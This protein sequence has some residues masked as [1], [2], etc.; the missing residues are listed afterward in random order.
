MNSLYQQ[1]NPTVNNLSLSRNSNIQ[2][3][4]S[5]FKNSPNP[6][7]LL[8]N[9]IKNNP[10]MQNLY[11]LIQNSNKTPK[12]LFYTMANEKGVDPNSILNL[13]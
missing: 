3:I 12:E 6:Q 11:M 1:L 4:I 10:Q 2:N 9:L 8:N 7:M 5:L 13:F